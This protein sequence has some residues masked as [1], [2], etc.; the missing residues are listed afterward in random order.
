M[1]YIRG[2]GGDPLN[3][4]AA[5]RTVLILVLSV[6]LLGWFV[7]GLHPDKMLAAFASVQPG[8]VVVAAGLILLEYA[9]RA[10]R[11]GVL[12]REVDPGVTYADLWRATTVGNAFNTLLPLRAGDV[13]RPAMLARRR[14]VPFTT[15]LSTAVVERLFE[16]GG[17]VVALILLLVYLP[18]EVVSGGGIIEDVQHH[19]VSVAVGALVILVLVVLLGSSGARS[20]FERIVSPLPDRWEHW[21][22]DTFEQLVA[23]LAAVGNPLRLVGAVILT[24]LSILCGVGGIWAL[25]QSFGVDLP[26]S[27]CLFVQLALMAE[28]AVPQAP[29]FLGGFH[30]VMEESLLLWSVPEGL[31]EASAILLWLVWFGPITLWGLFDASREGVSLTGFREDL[32]PQVEDS[33]EKG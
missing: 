9:V 28:I 6:A 23:G 12:H 19:G 18:P 7:S 31:A 11:W 13:V 2:L 27:A 30:F 14:G 15:V 4:S 20:L 16:L 17:V 25:F 33:P 1:G 24:A 32:G 29:G 8:W 26:V 3:R 22:I 21:A 10:L 5:A